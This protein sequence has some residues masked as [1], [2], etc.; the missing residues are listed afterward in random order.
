MKGR[1]RK[2]QWVVVAVFPD[3]RSARAC[4]KGEVRL[5]QEAMSAIGPHGRVI[6]GRDVAREPFSPEGR[7]HARDALLL[8]AAMFEGE[9]K[10]VRLE[11]EEA[12]SRADRLRKEASDAA[13][14][15]DRLGRILGEIE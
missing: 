5:A 14:Y 15:A 8:A 7:A 10:P 3:E 11:W 4:I 12:K 1:P 13:S 9:R 6:H 2:P